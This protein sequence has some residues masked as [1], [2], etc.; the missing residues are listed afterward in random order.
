LRRDACR[1]TGHCLAVAILCATGAAAA[2]DQTASPPV[3]DTCQARLARLAEYQP[4]ALAGHGGCGAADAVLLR[5]VILPDQTKVA[6]APAATLRCT[7]AE[8][9]AHWLREDVAPAALRFGSPLRSVDN[10]DS[11]DC[12]GRNRV[13]GAQLSEHGRANALDVRAFGLADGRTIELTDV[14][15][16][17]GWRQA[18]RA[19]AC[20][21]F[22]TVLGPG[23]DG[24]HEAHIHLDLAERHG[25]YK[26]CH[27]DVRAPMI[28]AGAATAGLTTGALGALVPLPRPRPAAIAPVS[29]GSPTVPQLRR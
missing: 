10:F 8:Q 3:P 23:S 13:A 25:G 26:Y 18:L 29:V 6:I 11:Y 21:R 28:E 19:S 14:R 22:V 24:F 15:V 16:A 4:L 27:W 20:A 1:L 17:K 12:R 9:I 2:Q 7:M 5:Y